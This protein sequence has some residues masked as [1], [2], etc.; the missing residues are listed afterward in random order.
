MAVHDQAGQVAQ[1]TSPPTD[2]TAYSITGHF[3]DRVGKPNRFISREIAHTAIRR[4][5]PQHKENGGWRFI[6]ATEGVEYT[7]I[8][9]DV[10]TSPVIVTGW[11]EVTDRDRAEKSGNWSEWELNIIQVRTALSKNN[12]RPVPEHLQPL[13]VNH[14]VPIKGHRV[15]LGHKDDQVTCIE[16]NLQTDAKCELSTKRCH[17]W[18][19]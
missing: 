6:Y 13:S 11:T 14:P 15:T 17:G 3:H 2:P 5:T 12:G 4:G 16:C 19:P 1:I 7:I 9:D 18:R 10:D 8:V